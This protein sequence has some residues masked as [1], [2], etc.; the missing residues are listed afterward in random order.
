M[1]TYQ[2]LTLI[3][4]SCEHLVTPPE[5]EAL[6]ACNLVTTLFLSG[7]LDRGYEPC[8]PVGSV[9]NLKF[10]LE[11]LFAF[12]LVAAEIADLL[13]EAFGRT[14]C[15]GPRYCHISGFELGTSK[16]VGCKKRLCNDGI[17]IEQETKANPRGNVRVLLIGINEKRKQACSLY[18]GIRVIR[19]TPL[20]DDI[21]SGPIPRVSLWSTDSCLCPPSASSLTYNDNG[22]ECGGS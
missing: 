15:T 2:V 10:L 8:R 17:A 4:M 7:R 19:K 16:N 22:H 13:G 6:P 3:P 5:R 1:L 14:V 21:K 9:D 12:R 11:F 18:S 20:L